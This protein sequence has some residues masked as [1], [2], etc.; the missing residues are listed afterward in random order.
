MP[1]KLIE[2]EKA[3]RLVLAEAQPLDTEQVAVGGALGRVLAER[4]TSPENVPGFD[5]SAMDGFAVIASETGGASEEQPVSLRIAGQSRAGSPAGSALR[6]GE[7]FGISTGA[8]V[9]EGA[10]A[11]VR[12][13]DTRA[14]DG[15]VQ[16]TAEAQPGLNIRRAGEDAAIGDVVLEPGTALGPSELGVL[17]S[18]A[19]PVAACVRRPRVSVLC[20][21]DELIGPDEPMRPGAVRNSNA[22]SVPAL[23]SLA[24][25][26]VTSVERTVDDPS[27]TVAALQRA[28]NADVAVVCGGMSVGEHDHVRPALQELGV[29]ERFWG[30]ALRPGKPTFFGVHEGGGRGRTLVFGLPGNPV[31]AVVTFILFVRPGLRSLSGAQPD[32]DRTVATLAAPYE[33][34]KPGRAHAVRCRLEL[35]ESGWKATPTGPQGS[36]VLTSMLGADALAII[37]GPAGPQPAGA[38]VEIELLQ[39]V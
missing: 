7:A 26:E 34:K 37:P 10:D 25:G 2:I 15:S 35:G 20:T 29:E 9:P 22:Y 39:R 12:V 30:V 27:E 1:A 36:H 18:A 33:E 32:V 38:R 8:A 21:G 13:E 14:S 31:S 5:N 6:G 17:V 23:A 4:I 24:G 19:R 28:L 11:V 16:V 3:R